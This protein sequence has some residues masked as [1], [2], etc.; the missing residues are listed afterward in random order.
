MTDMQ[1][2]RLP[3]EERMEG[4]VIRLDGRMFVERV[5][6]GVEETRGSRTKLQLVHYWWWLYL[7]AVELLY[8]TLPYLLT[9]PPPSSFHWDS[10]HNHV[11]I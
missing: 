1:K 3:V 6:E 10:I 8:C 2:I 5:S 7:C 4:S 11:L 9:A